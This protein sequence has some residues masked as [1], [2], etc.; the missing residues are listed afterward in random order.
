MASPNSSTG[1]KKLAFMR[2]HPFIILC[3]Q[4]KKVKPVATHVRFYSRKGR[5][6]IPFSMMMKKQEH[7]VAFRKTKVYWLFSM[8]RIL[9]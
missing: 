1:Q 6:L 5:A 3:E 9:M 2:Q 8:G 4:M 7:T